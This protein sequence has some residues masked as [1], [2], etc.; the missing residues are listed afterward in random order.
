[1]PARRGMQGEGGT[2]HEMGCFTTDVTGARCVWPGEIHRIL[3]FLPSSIHV[4]TH[5]V[6]PSPYPLSNP[7]FPPTGSLDDQLH[8]M[9]P[10][11]PSPGLGTTAAPPASSTHR[12][13]A[14]PSSS[15]SPP[16]PTPT[17]EHDPLRSLWSSAHLPQTDADRSCFCR[18]LVR[19][20]GPAAPEGGPW[21]EAV[22]TEFLRLFRFPLAAGPSAVQGQALSI[23]FG[24]ATEPAHT[25]ALF[26]TCAGATGSEGSTLLNLYTAKASVLSCRVTLHTLGKP[27][28]PGAQEEG[29]GEEVEGGLTHC[30]LLITP[31]CFWAYCKHP[32]LFSTLHPFSPTASPRL[33]F[34]EDEEDDARSDAARR[35]R[36]RRRRQRMLERQKKEEAE[37][38]KMEEEKGQGSADGI[39]EV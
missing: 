20:G 13:P 39:L 10:P 30:L 23:L 9:N 5:H 37:E 7:P 28:R 14:P 34:E 21:I 35:R 32:K 25:Q 22:D 4:P 26:A 19:L 33:R 27:P 15:S 36:L 3:S 6:H 29:E 2:R 11:P 17:T 18:V 16:F 31:V 24:P 38:A 12:P 1:M 8:R